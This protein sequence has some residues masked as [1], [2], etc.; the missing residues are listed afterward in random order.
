[1]EKIGTKRKYLSR[2]RKIG[3]TDKCIQ[4]LTNSWACSNGR[5]RKNKCSDDNKLSTSTRRMRRGDEERLL[6]YEH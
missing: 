1:M 4:S 2:L 6:F 5:S 3:R